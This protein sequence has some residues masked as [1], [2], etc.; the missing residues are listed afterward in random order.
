MNNIDVLYSNTQNKAGT[1]L[2]SSINNH[3]WYGALSTLNYQAS[4]EISLSGG[5]DMRYYKGQHYREVY[6]L[7]GADYAI[8][9]ANGMQNSQVKKVGDIVGYHNDGIVKWSGAFSQMEYNNGMLS[10][11][12]NISGSNSAYKRIDYFKKKD[13]VLSD[14]TYKEALGTSVNTVYEYDNAGNIIGAHK[15]LM[16]D[17]IW[18][19]G[20][21]NRSKCKLR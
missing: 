10:A 9:E 21:K 7:L 17:T 16:E 8:D 13:L 19:N 6:D 4:D 2:R 5:L 15:T 12:F 20:N 1:Y 11:F 3:F 14:T 18:H